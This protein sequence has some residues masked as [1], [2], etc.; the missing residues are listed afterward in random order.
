[1]E[2]DHSLLFVRRVWSNNLIQIKVSWLCARDCREAKEG[3]TLCWVH[4]CC[5]VI[6]HGQWQCVPKTHLKGCT[7]NKQHQ[8]GQKRIIA[9]GTMNRIC[10]TGI[11]WRL[12][13]TAFAPLSHIGILILIGLWHRP[14]RSSR[15]RRRS[16]Q[17]TTYCLHSPVD[18]GGGGRTTGGFIGHLPRQPTDQPKK[19]LAD[20][21]RL[22]LV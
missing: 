13:G 10:M 15:R 19:A 2:K 16:T 3:W 1:M 7:Y 11:T 12:W 4:G 5:F 17:A 20:P 21:L 18:G 22:W 9:I 14:C 6:W 8:G